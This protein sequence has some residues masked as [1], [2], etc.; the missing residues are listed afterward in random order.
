MDATNEIWQKLTYFFTGAMMLEGI[1][2]FK[3][4]TVIFLLFY[5]FY[6]IIV[7]RQVSLMNKFLATNLSSS[8]KVVAWA[9]C[10]FTIL[11]LLLV[12]SL[13]A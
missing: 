3:I 2:Y 9:Y 11:V 8:T 5:L 13:P 1:V 4:V 7:V 6:N 12:I 10:L